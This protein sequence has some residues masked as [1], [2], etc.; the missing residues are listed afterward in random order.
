MG[1]EK[2]ETASKDYP[3]WK[4]GM[5]WKGSEK[6]VTKNVKGVKK[7]VCFCRMKRL[8][9]VYRLVGRT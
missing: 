2:T 3:L 4:L 8:G 5:E 1:V 6:G 7:R 9:H